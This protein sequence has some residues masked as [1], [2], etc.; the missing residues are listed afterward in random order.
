MLCTLPLAC[1]LECLLR[2][3]KI[4]T[5][6]TKPNFCAAARHLKAACVVQ[7]VAYSIHLEFRYVR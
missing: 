2:R 5:S 6:Q 4:G 7:L 1:R 3:D